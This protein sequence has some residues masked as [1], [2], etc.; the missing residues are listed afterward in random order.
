MNMSILHTGRV[1]CI[2]TRY[3][4]P[5]LLR[6]FPSTV[7][8]IGQSLPAFESLG[9]S[10]V[11]FLKLLISFTPTT[12]VKFPENILVSASARIICVLERRAH[13]DKLR[14]HFPW[15]YTRIESLPSLPPK[16]IFSAG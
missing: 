7:I 13:R 10:W 16:F 4:L 14:R 5:R 12:V 2:V 1:I 9:S 15:G 8:Y 11:P 6:W 3:Y